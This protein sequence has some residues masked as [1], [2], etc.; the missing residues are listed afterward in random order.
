[1]K[2][3]W[4][5]S[6]Y[7]LYFGAGACVFPYFVLYYQGLGFSG[8]QIGILSAISPLITLAGAPFW[9]G[10]ADSTR[11]HKLVMSLAIL[12]CTGLVASYP[13]VGTFAVVLALGSLFAFMIAPVN[14]LADAATMSML[15]DQKNMYGRVRVGGAIGWGVIAPLSGIVIDRFGLDWAFWSYAVLMFI[16]FL[17]SQQFVFGHSAHSVSLRHGLRELFSHRRLVLFLVTTFVG[18]MA[19]MSIN[20]F[21]GAHMAALGLRKSAIGFALGLATVSEV[22]MLFYAD[23]LLVR[24]KPHGLLI[25][26][27]VATSLRLFLY[28]IFTTE[29]GILGFQLL[30]GF[31]FAALWVAGVSYVNEI[32]PPGLSATAQGIF[33]ATVFGFGAAVGGFLGAILVERVGGAQMFAI[34]GALLFAALIAYI[35]MERR[36]SRAQHAKI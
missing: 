6:F 14:S 8:A 33:S 28:A 12:V 20:S 3:I 25:L 21:L 24:L 30:N 7:L 2:K 19:L 5:F 1:M 18:G 22:P 16:G 36:L 15:G 4:P 11:R 17:V 13:F 29:A 9:T 26:S 32:A 10:I 31:T 35:L 23:R 34:F 27:M